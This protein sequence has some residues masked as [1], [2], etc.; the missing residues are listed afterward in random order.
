MFG[1]PTLGV[2]ETAISQ[3]SQLGL[4]LIDVLMTGYAVEDDGVEGDRGGKLLLGFGHK[5]IVQVEDI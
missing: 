5:E 2:E 1:S 4:G 3:G